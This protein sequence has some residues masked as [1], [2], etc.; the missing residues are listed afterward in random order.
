VADDVPLDVIGNGGLIDD[1][2]LRQKVGQVCDRVFFAGKPEIRTAA[3]LGQDR[4]QLGDFD[5]QFANFLALLS[6]L[7]HARIAEHLNGVPGRA[8]ELQQI[9]F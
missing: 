3:H 2:A 9:S 1:A 8:R 5:F 4:M 6:G 7:F